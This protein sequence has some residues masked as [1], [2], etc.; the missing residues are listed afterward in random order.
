M[1]TVVSL[2]LILVLG[3]VVHCLAPAPVVIKKEEKENE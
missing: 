1:T 3:Y 2:L